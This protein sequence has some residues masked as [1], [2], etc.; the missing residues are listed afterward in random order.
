MRRAHPR[1]ID[2]LPV[3][4][5]IRTRAKRLPSESRPPKPAARAIG[6]RPIVT[7]AALTGSISQS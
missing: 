6:V 3:L 1:R 5:L 4:A 2:G 7:V